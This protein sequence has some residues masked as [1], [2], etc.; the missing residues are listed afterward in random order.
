MGTNRSGLLPEE[1]ESP[2]SAGSPSSSAIATGCERATT[3][4]ANR[5]DAE[6]RSTADRV[7]LLSAPTVARVPRKRTTQS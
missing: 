7:P 1:G 3:E 5:A 2:Q 4:R 6:A